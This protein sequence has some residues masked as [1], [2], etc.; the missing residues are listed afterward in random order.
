MNKIQQ[1]FTMIELLVVIAIIGILATIALPAY[2]QYTERANFTE[3]ILATTSAKSAVEIC[4]ITMRTLAN[5]NTAS[6]A[7]GIEAS[8]RNINT[9]DRI[10]YVT[11]TG[12]GIIEAKGEGAAGTSTYKLT[13]EL[14][15][16]RVTWARTG[17]CVTNGIC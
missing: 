17:T 13:P 4:G 8:V 14:R 5:C 2:Q 1:G 6:A 12:A 9:S 11:V 7:A 16:G 3:V 10:Q 15:D